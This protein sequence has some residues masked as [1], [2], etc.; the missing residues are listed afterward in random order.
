MKYFKRFVSATLVTLMV[1]SV[2]AGALP[3]SAQ[4]VSGSDWRAGRIIDDSIFYNKNAMSVDQIQQFLNAKMPV[5]DTNGSQ[6]YGGT[7]R[8]AYSASKGVNTPF[9]CLKDYQENPSNHQNNLGGSVPPGAISAAQIIWNAGQQYS[10]NPQVLIVMLQKEQALV[11]DDWPWPLQYQGAM[12]YGCPDTA[13]CDADYYGFYNQVMNAARQFRLYANNPNNYNF[14]PGTGN[15]IRYNPNASCGSTSVVIENQATASLYNYTPYQPNQAAL[16]NLYGTGDGCSAYGNRNF[17]RMFND[18]FGRTSGEGYM[19]VK[20]SDP[21]DLRQWV[22]YGRLKQHIPDSQTLAAW[23]LQNSTLVTLDPSIIGAYSNGPDLGRLFIRQGDPTLYFADNG[24]RYR[25][26]WQ[27]MA[28]TWNFSGKTISGVPT[29]L[30]NLPI[31]SG[32]LTFT[33]KD[34]NSSNIYLVDGGN[35]SGKT[36]LRKFA[37]DTVRAAWEGNNP[38]YTVP[39]GDYWAE[40]SQAIGSELTSARITHNGNGYL[41]SGGYKTYLPSGVAGL[42]PSSSLTVSNA[43]Y[44]RLVDRGSASHLVRSANAP[45]VY[46]VDNGVKHQILWPDALNAWTPNG[47]PVTVVN[48]GFMSL[49]PGGSTIGNYVADSGGQLYVMDKHKTIVPTAL[50]TAYRAAGPTFSATPALMALFANNN[51]TLTYFLKGRST[52]QVYLLDNSGKRR[53]LEWTDKATLWGAYKT[54]VTELSDSVINSIATAAGPSAFV[55]DGTTE[56]VVE[57]GK[58]WTVNSAMKTDWGLTG[59]QVYT[60]GTLNHLPI[61]GQLTNTMRDTTGGYY[62]IAGGKSFGTVDVNIAQLWNLTSAPM[63]NEALIRS[64]VPNYMLTR[65]V[66]S[67]VNGDNR[68]F[69]VDKGVWYNLPGG[70]SFNLGIDNQSIMVLDPAAAPNTITDWTHYVVKNEQ[71][72]HYVIDA[73][74]KHFVPTGT[75]LN[76]WTNNGAVTPLNVSMAFTN[77]LRNNTNIERTIKAS[78]PSVYFIE[79]NAKRHIQYSDVY[80]RGYA[81]YAQVGDQLVNVLPN[82]PSIAN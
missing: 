29:E 44:N 23:G 77:V 26:P 28:D 80:N 37:D 17:W 41:V 49:I 32:D 53:H 42:Y 61:A 1:G 12:G 60:D 11:Q 62:R 27:S 78:G 52:P 36:V 8:K 56:Y 82:G 54:G 55:S 24:R 20:S 13:A 69:V 31:D 48:D 75:I 63:H 25:V 51:Q 70:W 76:Q 16:N 67:S 47:S 40:I 43:T 15:N 7:T 73:G 5:C 64:T 72:T 66:R 46:L 6:P 35:G 22:V 14:V 33:V 50:E 68:T 3:Q 2:L 45:Q 81:P 30:A 74:T 4:A 10:I 79:N 59:A 21:N 65:F 58:R 39:S 34:P 19:R 9:I 38:P 18:W 71:N 57:D